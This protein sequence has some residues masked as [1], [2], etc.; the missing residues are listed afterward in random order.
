LRQRRGRIGRGRSPPGRGGDDRCGSEHAPAAVPG[1]RDD[2][3]CEGAAM[4]AGTG[5][6]VRRPARPP[7][8][9]LGNRPVGRSGSRCRACTWR[10]QRGQP[11]G[12]PPVSISR[13]HQSARGLPSCGTGEEQAACEAS[14]SGD[15]ATAVERSCA[16]VPRTLSGRGRPRRGRVPDY[17][18]LLRTT[19]PQHVRCRRRAGGSCQSVTSGIRCDVP[20]PGA[21]RC[22]PR[23]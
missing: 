13:D 15:R 12:V 20:V 2:S 23:A 9:A 17:S 5:L 3:W 4:E 1:P 22:S 16:G 21:P 14:L 6:D 7:R 11:A 8:S 18:V 10:V 19:R